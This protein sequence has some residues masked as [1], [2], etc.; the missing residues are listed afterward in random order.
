MLH[1]KLCPNSSPP[2]G[3]KLVKDV[4]ARGLQWTVTG[5]QQGGFGR[6]TAF[7]AAA[8]SLPRSGS[9]SLVRLVTAASL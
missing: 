1:P 7:A 4:E 5:G 2:Q 8:C 6:L 3:F 9:C